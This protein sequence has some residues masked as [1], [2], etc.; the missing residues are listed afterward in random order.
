VESGE[1]YV[2][3]W[4]EGKPKWVQSLGENGVEQETLSE[5]MQ[6]KVAHAL[7]VCL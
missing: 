6:A 4:E 2:G 7:Q 1:R 3:E 5:E